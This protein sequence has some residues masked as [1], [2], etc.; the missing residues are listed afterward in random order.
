MKRPCFITILIICL[1]FTGCSSVM[2]TGKRFG[3]L[4]EDARHFIQ[5]AQV[6]LYP[7]LE[8]AWQ[9]LETGYIYRTD[10]WYIADRYGQIIPGG[11]DTWLMPSEV[12]VLINAG[13]HSMDCEDGAIWL[14]SA[15]RK[16]GYDA[17]FCV[18]SVTLDSGIYSHAWCMVRENGAWTLYETTTGQTAKGLPKEYR[19]SWRTNGETTQV[20]ISLTGANRADPIP[21][22]QLSELRIALAN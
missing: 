19:L 5:P 17:W 16:Q 15:F 6:D 9:A 12:Q 11:E 8:S 7:S 22:E 21:P 4:P 20:N 1:M 3:S 14:A 2:V 10:D 13:I 18:G